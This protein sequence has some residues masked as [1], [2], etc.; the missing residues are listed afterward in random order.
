MS[1]PHY[2]PTTKQL[3]L[4]SVMRRLPFYNSGMSAHLFGTKHSKSYGE[5]G[6]PLQMDFWYYKHVYDRVGLARAVVNLPVS[7]C[8]LTHPMIKD[9]KTEE[10]SEQFKEFAERTGYWRSCKDADRTQRVGHYGGMIV[11]VR[12]GKPLSA[13]LDDNSISLDDIV[14]FMPFWEGQLIPGTIDSNQQSPRYGLPIEYT[15]NNRGVFKPNQRDGGD[16]FT[17]HHTRVRIRNEGAIGRTIYGESSIEP[18]FNALI[19]WEKKRGAG[20]EGAWRICAARPILKA[21]AETA[22]QAP[23]PEEMQ[24]LLEAIGD[25][26]TSFDSVP[27]LGGMDVTTLNQDLPDLKDYFAADISEIAAGSGIS[28]A[29]LIGNQTGKLAG[30]KDSS[31]DKEMAQSRREGYLSEEIKLDLKWLGEICKDFDDRGL[32]VYWDDLSA[33]SDSVRF[34]NM[35][36]LA[37]ALHKF[38]SAKA[39]GGGAV[40]TDNEFRELGQFLPLPELDELPFKEGETGG[41]P[42]KPDPVE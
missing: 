17:V 8:W 36:K 40:I 22:G 42:E 11:F 20:G 37:D 13:P 1:K 7:L 12:D 21:L 27:Y 30:D 4:N 6:W 16:S 24:A 14:E 33:P 2:R 15:Y 19:D 26:N 31:H 35:G 18:V 32:I 5:Y 28:Q 34:E 10:E 25:M 3:A 38:A 39:L 23:E 41:D 29:G 9:A